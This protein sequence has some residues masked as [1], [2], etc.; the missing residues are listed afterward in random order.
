MPCE[1]QDMQSGAGPVGTI[2]QSAIVDLDVVRLYRALARGSNLR[3][4]LGMAYSIRAE[5]HRVFIRRGNE[6]SDL[7]HGKRI[8]NIKNAS[9]RIKPGKD[10]QYSPRILC[11]LSVLPPCPLC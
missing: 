5:K 1:P 4:A 7:L 9:P 2:N 11:A 6:I 3:I 10:G 8:A